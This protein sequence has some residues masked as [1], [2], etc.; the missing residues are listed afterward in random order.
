MADQN[1]K[2]ARVRYEVLAPVFV[3]DSYVDPKA[4]LPLG[5]ER[6][7]GK[8][9]VWAAPGLAGPALKFDEEAAAP[10]PEASV[11]EQGKSPDP[12]A[13]LTMRLAKVAEEHA[14]FEKQL[15]DARA[16]VVVVA[17]QRDELAQKLAAADETIAGL[18]AKVA[19]LEKQLAAAKKK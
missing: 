10:T 4:P 18:Q 14:A 13:A 11:L 19:E 1:G 17:Q 6:K 5:A 16:E 12:N 7:G 15:T 8:V 2:T 9:Y 3:N